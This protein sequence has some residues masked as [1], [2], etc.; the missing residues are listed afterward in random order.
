MT[1]L[2]IV[3]GA[4][5][6]IGRALT[7]ELAARGIRVL[8]VGRDLQ[9]L[10]ETRRH[11]PALIKI[12]AADIATAEGREAVAA[13]LSADDPIA[14]LVHNAA[15]LEPV[16][17][18]AAMSLESWRQAQAINVEGPLFLTQRLL[19]HLHGGR[20]LHISSGAAH[21]AY[22]GW[23]AY[24]ASKAALYM[25]YQV[26]REELREFDIKVGS[27][28]PG[29]VD[30]PMQDLIRALPKERFPGVNRFI[31]LK[32]SGQLVTPGDAASFLAWTLLKTTDQ[33]FTEAELDINET[34][35]RWQAFQ[36]Q[37]K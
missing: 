26:L 16:G 2:A 20:L 19:P 7:W 34:K 32:Q 23:G 3:T 29:V 35:S 22:I 31:Q 10:E 24:C 13:S 11:A 28:R 14:Y 33:E 12:I 1:S 8:G 27:A 6:G 17:T 30:T 5:S 37:Q 15:V 36:R 21:R 18:L 4:S 25:L 9:R